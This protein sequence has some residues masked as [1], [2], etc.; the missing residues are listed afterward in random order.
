M[1]LVLVATGVAALAAYAHQHPARSF[2]PLDPYT[3]WLV[4]RQKP[5]LHR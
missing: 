2:A 5:S 4:K 1:E 3:G